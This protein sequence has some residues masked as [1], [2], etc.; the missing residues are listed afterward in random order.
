MLIDETPRCPSVTIYT[1]T[2]YMQQDLRWPAGVDVQCAASTL[3]SVRATSD[4]SIEPRISSS[5]GP[6]SSPAPSPATLNK[7][8]PQVL[9]GSHSAGSPALSCSHWM[10]DRALSL[11]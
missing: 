6:S 2:V 11:S 3:A 9:P 4:R 10:R 7:A 8:V 5:M 1:S